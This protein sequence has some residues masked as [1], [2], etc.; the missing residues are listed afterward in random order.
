VFSPARGTTARTGTAAAPHV[1]EGEIIEEVWRQRETTAKRVME[2]LN[3]KTGPTALIA[4]PAV[5]TIPD[6][7]HVTRMG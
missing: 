1:L 7:E 5:S 3:R 6:G 2:V 4:V